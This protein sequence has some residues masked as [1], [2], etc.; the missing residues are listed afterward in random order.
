PAAGVVFEADQGVG[1]AAVP[2]AVVDPAD[3]VE[4][5]AAATAGRPLGLLRPR[6]AVDGPLPADLHLLREAA[7]QPV[8]HVDRA[9]RPGRV[10]EADDRAL[11][12][13]GVRVVLGLAVE[14]PVRH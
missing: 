6:T 9:V 14:G 5:A 10:A 2:G 12:P 1:E 4:G 3:A 8:V 11:D 13:A 7:R